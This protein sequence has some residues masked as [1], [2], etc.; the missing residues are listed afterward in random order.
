LKW[1]LVIPTNRK[2]LIVKQDIELLLKGDYSGK[3][4]VPEKVKRMAKP[5]R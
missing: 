2:D 4:V 5:E 1:L 3:I